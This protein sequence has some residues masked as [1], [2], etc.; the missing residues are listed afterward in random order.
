[1]VGQER[2]ADEVKIVLKPYY[3]KATINKE[4]YKQI[5]RNSVTKVTV[6]AVSYS[7]EL[8]LHTHIQQ[9]MSED[10]SYH[11]RFPLLQIYQKTQGRVNPAKVKDFVEKYVATV[12]RRRT[13]QK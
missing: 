1:M 5:M 11:I 9:I 7:L 4:E 6:R 8:S 13:R 12:I 10:D 3:C 2:I